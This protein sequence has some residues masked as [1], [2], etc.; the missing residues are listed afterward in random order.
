VANI[1]LKIV[2]EDGMPVVG[3]P[4][5]IGLVKTMAIPY[6]VSEVCGLSDSNGCFSV[7]GETVR[8]PMCTIARNDPDVYACSFLSEVSKK[9]YMVV[10]RKRGAPIPLIRNAGASCEFPH[11]EESVEYDCFRCD[12]LPPYGKGRVGDIKIVLKGGVRDLADED[13][14]EASYWY[15]VKLGFKEEGGG[16]V[17]QQTTDESHYKYTRIAKQNWTW[18]DAL[19]YWRKGLAGLTQKT[20][21]NSNDNHLVIRVIRRV[22][23]VPH[24]YYGVI[25]RFDVDIGIPDKSRHIE[26]ETMINPNPD[27]PNI[28]F[29]GHALKP[30]DPKAPVAKADEK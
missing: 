13:A 12:F 26:I 8:C 29:D 18:S 11:P 7:R 20:E 19:H 25:K 17:L 14:L 16:A 21:F 27:D 10:L 1:N 22:A 2:D 6:K 30:Q 28:E 23:G 24:F 9:D 5:E 4:C 3:V 15:D